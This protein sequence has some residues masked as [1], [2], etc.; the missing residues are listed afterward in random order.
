MVLSEEHRQALDDWFDVTTVDIRTLTSGAEF[1]WSAVLEDK[2]YDQLLAAPSSFPTLFPAVQQLRALGTHPCPQNRRFGC[3]GLPKVDGEVQYYTPEGKLVSEPAGLLSLTSLDTASEAVTREDVLRYFKYRVGAEK[4]SAERLPLNINYGLAATDRWRTLVLQLQRVV[5]RQEARHQREI[6]ALH[7]QARRHA[8]ALRRRVASQPRVPAPRTPSTG[9]RWA[10]TQL[11]SDGETSP[12]FVH[13]SPALGNDPSPMVLDDPEPSKPYTHWSPAPSVPTTTRHTSSSLSVPTPRGPAAG[14]GAAGATGAA[15]TGA[16]SPPPPPPREPATWLPTRTATPT[17]SG[18]PSHAA[19][20]SDA[21]LLEEH[22]PPP[23]HSSN[24]GS[25][26]QRTLSPARVVHGDK[27]GGQ[28]QH[29][30][31]VVAHDDAEMLR[32][33]AE[34]L[35]ELRKEHE[36]QLA[37]D[38]VRP[39]VVPESVGLENP[40]GAHNCFLNV[41]LQSLWHLGDFRRR[42]E[43]LPKHRCRPNCIFCAVR[44]LFTQYKFGSYAHM[45][46]KDV[47]EVVSRIFS[48]EQRFQMDQ[49]DD[50]AEM[51]DA[52]LQQLHLETASCEPHA[53]CQPP[54]LSHAVFAAEIIERR[55]RCPLCRDPGEHFNSYV[56]FLHYFPAS[57]VGNSGPLEGRLRA[58]LE[59]D[60]RHCKNCKPWENSNIIELPIHKHMCNLPP[61]FACVLAWAGEQSTR[62]ALQRVTGGIGE[63]LQLGDVFRLVA[64]DGKSPHPHVLRGMICFY[65]RH[66]MAYF[67][68]RIQARWVFIDDSSVR[69]V[70]DWGT[71]CQ[72][73]VDGRHMPLVLFYVHGDDPHQPV[74]PGSPTSPASNTAGR[75]PAASA[76]L[77]GA[78]SRQGPDALARSHS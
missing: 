26:P 33:Q 72:N 4:A 74:A 5:G 66:Y 9:Q 62:E 37:R 17:A 78:A 6:A 10:D 50:A 52:I 46:P 16:A 70:G 19:Q 48:Q 3:P 13:S 35:R 38:R 59:S 18:G 39:P 34:G 15:S 45:P 71:V 2:V 57:L 60:V 21:K 54:C 11:R 51:L 53:P 67:W 23:S 68:N 1:F 76:Q 49:M 31:E 7:E 14:D 47:R 29:T 42:V 64:E 30:Y 12:A 36:Q 61:I 77:L 44:N 40:V 73:I 63:T 24:G 69:P 20:T 25:S 27:N 22:L 41:V 56:T 55:Q 58:H 8:E 28:E 65:G 75:F 43:E 32:Q